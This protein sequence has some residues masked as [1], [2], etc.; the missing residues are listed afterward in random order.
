M[1]P[2][3]VIGRESVLTVLSSPKG[4]EEPGPGDAD[5]VV[6][7]RQGDADAFRVLYER[8]AP[9]VLG[10]LRHRLGDHALA[11]DALQDTFVNAYRALVSF[12]LRRPFGPWVATIAENLAVDRFRRRS[13]E[14]RSLAPADEAPV[15]ADP[16][17]AAAAREREEVV[18]AALSGLEPG[19]RRVLLLRYQRGLSQ[20]ATADELGCS[21]RTVQTREEAALEA[22]AALLDERRARRAKG[23]ATGETD[24]REGKR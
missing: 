10:F 9:A 4:K 14:P 13:L 6:R 23:E 21:L 8:Y 2:R 18:R 15:N 1:I 16:G 5:L 7:A 11:E 24:S 3:R 12:D 17:A 19:P 20:R 22:L